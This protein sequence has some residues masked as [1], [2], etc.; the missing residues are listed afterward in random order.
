MKIYH[1][2]VA[3]IIPLT[4]LH[5][6]DQPLLADLGSSGGDDLWAKAGPFNK[7]LAN[8]KLNAP[9]I[10]PNYPPQLALF[11]LSLSYNHLSA[12]ADY[13]NFQSDDVKVEGREVEGSLS[14]EFHPHAVLEVADRMDG[15]WKTIGVSPPADGGR[16]VSVIMKPNAPKAGKYPRNRYCTIDMDPFRPWAYKAKYGRVVLQGGENS[17]IIALIDLLPPPDQ[18]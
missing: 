1:A 4:V 2:I 14:S 7:S 17:Q 15:P 8:G 16:A 10:D 9:L 5:G 3:L 12:D 6:D 13:Y 11:M 18:R